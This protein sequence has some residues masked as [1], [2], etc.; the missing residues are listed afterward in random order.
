MKNTGERKIGDFS[1]ALLLLLLSW[2]IVMVQLK[3]IGFWIFIWRPIESFKCLG[4]NAWVYTR[5]DRFLIFCELAFWIVRK[6]Y[7]NAI[8]TIFVLRLIWFSGFPD[9]SSLDISSSDNSS[10][11]NF[12]PDNSSPEK[13]FVGQFFARTIFRWTIL[14]MDNSSPDNSSLG[15]F[16]A[17]QFFAQNCFLAK[18]TILLPEN[19]SPGQ[20]FDWTILRSDNSSTGQFFARTILRWTILR[21]DSSSLEN[22]CTDNG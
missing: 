11:D 18:R 3:I 9:S 5:V 22:F 21:P 7:L 12:S 17:G 10:S 2:S 15:Q 4:T 8:R 19:S 16:F 13:F 6:S 14:R 1:L 20:F